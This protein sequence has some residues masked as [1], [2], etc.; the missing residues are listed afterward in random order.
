MTRFRI[1]V[2]GNKALDFKK[3]NTVLSMN[4]FM[5]TV[6]TKSKIAYVLYWSLTLG[7]D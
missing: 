6:N 1:V 7:A 3:V 2:K 4:R 5:H